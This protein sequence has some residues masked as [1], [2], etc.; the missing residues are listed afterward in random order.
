MVV[1]LCGSAL[2]NSHIL[3]NAQ[4]RKTVSEWLCIKCEIFR[5]ELS[6]FIH[7]HFRTFAFYYYYYYYYYYY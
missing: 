3:D 5:I 7:V 4:V 1:A 6:Y 2:M